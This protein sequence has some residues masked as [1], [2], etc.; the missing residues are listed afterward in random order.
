MSG[1]DDFVVSRILEPKKKALLRV[2][3]PNGSCF[4]HHCRP[5]SKIT[6]WE[7]G[8]GTIECVDG[9]VLIMSFADCALFE[10]YATPKANQNRSLTVTAAGYAQYYSRTGEP[11]PA[12]PAIKPD[13]PLSIRF[14]GGSNR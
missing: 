2:R 3:N 10:L 6:G 7:G 11:R 14:A 13:Q 4:F 9:A 1:K 5:L 12:Y 8:G